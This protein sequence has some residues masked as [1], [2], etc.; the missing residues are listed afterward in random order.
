MVSKMLPNDVNINFV[1]YC[2]FISASWNNWKQIILGETLKLDRICNEIVEKIKSES[3]NYLFRKFR[4][5]N[6]NK[7]WEKYLETSAEDWHGIYLLPFC[8]IKDTN[9]KTFSFNYWTEFCFVTHPS[10]NVNLKKQKYAL[11]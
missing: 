11:F 7:K 1:D 8:I 3:K 2:G 6:C 10:R 9:Y 5:N 4:K